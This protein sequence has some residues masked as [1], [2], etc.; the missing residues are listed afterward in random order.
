MQHYRPDMTKE[1]VR[2]LKFGGSS[3]ATPE[4]YHVVAR[5]LAVRVA[6]GERLCVVVSAMSGTT[7]RL[8]ELLHSIAPS[9]EP[10]DVDAALGTGEILASTLVRAVLGTHRVDAVSL[11]A[12]QLGWRAS[13]DFTAGQLTDF[14]DT[15][16]ADALQRVPVVVISGGQ[17]VTDDNR[18][19]ML[20]R[21]SSDLTAIAVAVA[22]RRPAVTIYSDV[23]GVFTADPY[24]LADT[25]LIP[26]LGYRHAKAY[27]QWGAKVLHSGCIELAERHRVRIQCASLSAEGG[28]SIGTE[29][30]EDGQGV[31]VCL[32]DNV[33]ICRVPANG[34][35]FAIEPF[36]I[37]DQPDH[38]AARLDD[39][40]CELSAA[41][42]I[43]TVQ[44]LAPVVS[45]SLDGA[46]HIHAVP[47]AERETHA[48]EIHDRLVKG[49]PFPKVH[50]ALLKQRGSHSGVYGSVSRGA[51]A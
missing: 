18:L 1:T 25:S 12:F 19:V 34:S 9:P 7:G 24:R 22:M 45:F 38:F 44:E 30:A 49:T 37:V 2:V 23:E 40:Y 13:A 48:Q 4:A 15:V 51:P 5:H 27:S 26:Q 10:Q 31:Q 20:G 36:P 42:A 16:I 50:R 28:T 47:K 46:R 21:N 17:A 43:T 32:P 3:F 35:R 33:V 29:I 39:R 8:S 6:R 14:P 11:N 41:G